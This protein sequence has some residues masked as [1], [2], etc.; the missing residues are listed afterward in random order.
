MVQLFQEKFT[1]ST[2]FLL[3]CRCPNEAVVNRRVSFQNNQRL[4]CGT[5]LPRHL[6][7]AAFSAGPS[8]WFLTTWSVD[9]DGV[10]EKNSFCWERREKRRRPLL[11]VVCVS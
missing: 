10:R 8:F 1:Q 6:N 5:C 9:F 2:Q 3:I 11:Y 7:P 4:R